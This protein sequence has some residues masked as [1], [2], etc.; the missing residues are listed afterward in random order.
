MCLLVNQPASTIF[1]ED[2][3]ADVFQKHGAS[4]G[5]P[6]AS[7]LTHL[8]NG[9]TA[10]ES[11]GNP[12][13]SMKNGPYSHGYAPG[14]WVDYESPEIGKIPTK[15]SPLWKSDPAQQLFYFAA[16]SLARRHFPDVAPTA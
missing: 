10:P 2:F 11:D 15:N 3:L 14:Q 8:H 4:F 12:H 1:T 7:F 6:D 9:H 13:Y 5:A 16:R